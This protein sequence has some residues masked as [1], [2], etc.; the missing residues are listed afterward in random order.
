MNQKMKI[1]E[2]QGVGALSVVHNISRVEGCVG[3]QGWKLGRMTSGPIIHKNL[4]KPNNKLI[5][6]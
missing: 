1:A 3:P 5:S 6:A 2:G 4:R